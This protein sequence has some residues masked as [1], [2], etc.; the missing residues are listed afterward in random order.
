MSVL[1][2]FISN[3]IGRWISVALIAAGALGGIYT[4]GQYDGRQA[5]KARIES[6]KKTAIEKGHQGTADALKKLDTD[7]IPDFWFRD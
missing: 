5:V 6:E 3:P 7:S 4:K 1:W 2:F